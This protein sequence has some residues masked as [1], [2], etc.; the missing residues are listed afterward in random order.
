MEE[1]FIKISLKS[2]PK[3]YIDDLNVDG[4]LKNKTTLTFWH[5]DHLKNGLEC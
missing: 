5:T 4:N 2:V 1:D 3:T